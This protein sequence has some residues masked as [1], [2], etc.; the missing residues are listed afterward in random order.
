MWV[1]LW[2]CDEI[3][4]TF[5]NA[6]SLKHFQLYCTILQIS[7]I[8]CPSISIFLC[9]SIFTHSHK[10]FSLDGTDVREQKRERCLWY[11]R[12]SYWKHCTGS[13][14]FLVRLRD[15][16]YPLS[17]YIFYKQTLKTRYMMRWF[18]L[19]NPHW[20]QCMCYASA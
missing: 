4:N 5:T 17:K 9:P 19:H 10:S 2:K 16:H 15:P 6:A 3:L 8:L 20:V 1:I 11:S 12:T 14:T 7:T 13:Q 18:F